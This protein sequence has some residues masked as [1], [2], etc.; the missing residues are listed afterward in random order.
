MIYLPR[1]AAMFV[2]A[3]LALGLS[4]CTTERL[5]PVETAASGD[6]ATPAPDATSGAGGGVSEDVF[7]ERDAFFEAQGGAPDPSKPLVAVTPEQK[8]FVAQQRAYVAE[9]GGQVDEQYDSV[10]LALALDVCETS[11]LNGHQVDESTFATH[12]ATSP[13]VAALLPADGSEEERTSAER[14]LMSVAVFGTSFL[15]PDDAPNWQ[16][17]AQTYYGA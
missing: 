5:E 16:Q 9:Q 2:I 1:I 14:N 3:G 4:A 7:V 12:V 15:C 13:L 6:A 10:I 8:D 11:I 17:A